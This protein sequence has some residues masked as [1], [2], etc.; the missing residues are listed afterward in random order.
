MYFVVM[1]NELKLGVNNIH[2]SNLLGGCPSHFTF[3]NFTLFICVRVLNMNGRNNA[4]ETRLG[5][6]FIKS[7]H[8]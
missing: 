6:C 4:K 1:K 8:L 2:H 3:I 7:V 5:M